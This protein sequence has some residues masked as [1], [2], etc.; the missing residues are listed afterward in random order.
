MLLFFGFI[1]NLAKLTRQKRT[2]LM[3]IIYFFSDA[4]LGGH[5]EKQEKR[6]DFF[7]G[8]L[9]NIG[10]I[11]VAGYIYWIIDYINLYNDNN[12]MKTIEIIVVGIL[13]V[14]VEFILIKRYLKKRRYLAI[15]MITGII[16]PL[17]IIGTCSPF[18]FNSQ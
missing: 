2:F 11:V 17:L 1:I 4:H 15:G 3:G 16:I 14:I 12:M 13:I 7:L 9:L 5:S 18:L 8:F 6:K 10:I